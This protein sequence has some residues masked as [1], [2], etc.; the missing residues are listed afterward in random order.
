MVAEDSTICPIWQEVAIA[1][2]SVSRSCYT[3]L[4]A[5]GQRRPEK[6]TEYPVAAPVVLC[7]KDDDAA[8][9]SPEAGLV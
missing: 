5:L 6:E 1:P 2:G 8:S 7:E 9:L 4:S 3:S